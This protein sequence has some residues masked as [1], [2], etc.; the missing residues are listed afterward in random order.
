M[1]PKNCWKGL[2]W[3][4]IPSC[5]HW[6]AARKP[7]SSD[8][9]LF[10]VWDGAGRPVDCLLSVNSRSGLWTP[11]CRTDNKEVNMVETSRELLHQV[12][13]LETHC[14]LAC[15]TVIVFFVS[16][17]KGCTFSGNSIG[18]T[19]CIWWSD[20]SISLIE[21]SP[22][23]RSSFQVAHLHLLPASA[24]WD[25]ERRKFCSLFKLSLQI[26]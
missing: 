22:S 2:I 7:L 18:L 8:G 13:E 10:T 16:F 11:I 17:F 24:S 20:C 6:L 9:F 3:F 19:T 5:L 12:V 23:R 14:P 26:C 15:I 1:S 21:W 25:H 4:R